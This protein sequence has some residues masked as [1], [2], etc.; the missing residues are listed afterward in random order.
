MSVIV[1]I[2]FGLQAKFD[3]GRVIT[4]KVLF[5]CP[6]CNALYQIVKIDDGPGTNVGQVTCHPCGAPLPSRH[7]K[8][9]VKYFLLRTAA[10]KQKWKRHRN[11]KAR[12]RAVKKQNSIAVVPRLLS[13]D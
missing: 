7:G 11:E 4:D 1:N 8:F 5:N 9:V 3:V 13:R 10:Y 2:D 6:N 12:Q